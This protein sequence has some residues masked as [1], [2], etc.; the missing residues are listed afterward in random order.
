[1]A[2]HVVI[3]KTAVFARS[4][5]HLLKGKYQYTVKCKRCGDLSGGQRITSQGLADLCK[6]NHHAEV[7]AEH[8]AKHPNDKAHV[9]TDLRKRNNGRKMVIL[10]G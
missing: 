8:H 10:R 2:H 5:G 9:R 4:D 1:M 3:K 6:V 7:H